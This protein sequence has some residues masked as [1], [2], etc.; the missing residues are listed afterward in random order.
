MAF[1]KFGDFKVI[2]KFDAVK[3]FHDLSAFKEQMTA[4]LREDRPLHEEYEMSADGNAHERH[5]LAGKREE[6][7]QLF[8][9]L[10]PQ[11]T[12]KKIDVSF[13]Y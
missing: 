7:L 8:Q 3:L 9:Q 6:Y 10:V 13:S 11:A 2:D 5:E 4:R 12:C 1:L